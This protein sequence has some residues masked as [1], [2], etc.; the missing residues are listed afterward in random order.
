M[1]NSFDYASFFIYI[2]FFRRFSAV[3]LL[4]LI[5]SF[6][7]AFA[8]TQRLNFLLF[9]PRLTAFIEI[10]SL[11]LVF[12]WYFISSSEYLAKNRPDEER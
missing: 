11:N 6:H 10:H 9:G 12:F 7:T 4:F 3:F 5:F 8:R 2:T 1:G